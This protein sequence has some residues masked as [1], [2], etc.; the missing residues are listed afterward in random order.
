M[1]AAF[2]SVTRHP[3]CASAWIALVATM[4]LSWQSGGMP[5]MAAQTYMIHVKAG[6][7]AAKL[8][9]GPCT[10]QLLYI[11]TMRVGPTHRKVW[12]PVRY[13]RRWVIR[14]DNLTHFWQPQYNC[15]IYTL[16]TKRSGGKQDA[17]ATS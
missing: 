13:L 5:C 7:V 2:I 14:S 11:V 10:Q 12:I 16:Q 4:Q 6:A 8:L 17:R 3:N 1:H 15:W 9:A